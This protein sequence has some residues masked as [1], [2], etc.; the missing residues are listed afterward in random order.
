[1]I[2][3]KKKRK[4]VQ[5]SRQLRGEWVSALRGEGTDGP[6]ITFPAT[7]APATQSLAALTTVWHSRR[8]GTRPEAI[9]DL[10]HVHHGAILAGE[11]PCWQACSGFLAPTLLAGDSITCNP[12]AS[13]CGNEDTCVKIELAGREFRNMP[14]SCGHML[15]FKLSSGPLC[16]TTS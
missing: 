16:V 4:C 7:A 13:V 2:D 11:W 1:M 14:A 9:V 15:R 8:D 3:K 5:G 12:P 6:P 10:Q